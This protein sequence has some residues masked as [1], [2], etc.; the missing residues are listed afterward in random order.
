MARILAF[1]DTHGDPG[2]AEAVLALARRER[3]DLVACA[4]DLTWFGSRHEAS[5]EKLRGLGRDVYFVAGNHEWDRPPEAM[6]AGYP[7]LKDATHRTFEEAGVRIGGL[8]A[9]P[10]YWPGGRA[11]REAVRKALELWGGPGAS[12]PLVLL[13]H[14]PPSK[15]AVSGIT[16]ITPDSGGSVLVRAIVEG[17]RPALVVCGHYHQDSGK[18]G[19]LGG[20]RLENPGPEGKVLEI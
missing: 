1:T 14:F 3:P 8:P 5:L 12:K 6:F 7:F 9:T 4:G 16:L 11:D 20:T 17:V 19:I 15:T 2:A 10:A 18:S 13:S